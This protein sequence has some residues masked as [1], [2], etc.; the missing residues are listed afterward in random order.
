MIVKNKMKCTNQIQEDHQ[1]EQ[2]PETETGFEEE[3]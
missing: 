1:L 3:I 2:S